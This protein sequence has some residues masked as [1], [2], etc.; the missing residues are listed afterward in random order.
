MTDRKLTTHTYQF[1][2]KKDKWTFTIHLRKN[3]SFSVRQFSY[4][5]GHN[6]DVHINSVWDTYEEA[7]ERVNNILQ[8]LVIYDVKHVY[9]N[10]AA[11]EAA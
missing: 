3:G 6:V 10:K 5:E 7:Q 11:W 1:P 8:T 4:R 2:N 9:P